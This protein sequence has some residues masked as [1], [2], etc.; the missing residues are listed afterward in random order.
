MKH[1]Q[2]SRLRR[3]TYLVLR[4][5]PP[6]ARTLPPLA[7]SPRVLLLGNH[8]RLQPAALRRRARLLAA[9]HLEAALRRGR[10]G[11]ELPPGFVRGD[12]FGV[13]HASFTPELCHGLRTLFN[14]SEENK[15]N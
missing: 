8:R 9:N 5:L 7:L 6:L 13:F 3:P 1:K 10:R 15:D 2:K 11:F 4:G 12:H 14:P